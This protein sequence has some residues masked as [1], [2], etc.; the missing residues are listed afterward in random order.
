MKFKFEFLDLTSFISI[1]SFEFG[2]LNLNYEF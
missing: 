2:I 1:S